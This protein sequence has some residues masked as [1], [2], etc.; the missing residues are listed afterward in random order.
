MKTL[1]HDAV[2]KRER[3]MKRHEKW[4]GLYIILFYTFIYIPIAVS[5]VFSFN[6]QKKNTSWQGFTLD[7]WQQLFA[8]SDIWQVV[9][10]TLIVALVSTAFATVIGT[11]GAVGMVRHEFKGK[12]LLNSAVYVPIV[13]PEIVLAVALL[14]IYIKI[15]FPLGLWSI[16][17]GHT[18]LTLPFVVI[19]VKSRLAGYEKSLEE[20]AMDLGANQRQTFFKVTLPM[21]LPGILSGSFLAFTLSLDD[22]AI[23][24]FV[25]GIKST[26]LPLE[27]QSMLRSGISPEINALTTLIMLIVAGAYIIFKVVLP[28]QLERRSEND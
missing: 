9:L 11:L 24:N 21:I 12:Q 13:I 26:T 25:T 15:D 8:D 18:T 20:A 7:W 4:Y 3:R 16:I 10:N 19:N 1:E 2:S 17:L 22:L 23:S 5:I 14:C 28:K 6:D 27:I